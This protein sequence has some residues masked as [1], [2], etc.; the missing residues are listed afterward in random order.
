M[1]NKKSSSTNDETNFYWFWKNNIDPFSKEIPRWAPYDI[2]VNNIIETAFRKN[3]SVKIK[4]GDDDYK[5]DI[6]NMLQIKCNDPNR[7]R[8]IKRSKYDE[9]INICR[10]NRFTTFIQPSKMNNF[11]TEHKEEKN[12]QK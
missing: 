2:S 1:N 10:E 9:Y 4:F 3:E 12:L 8:P 5:I 6:V 7:Q 11:I